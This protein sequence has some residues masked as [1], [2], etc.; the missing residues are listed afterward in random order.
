VLLQGVFGN[1]IMNGAG[2]FMS[3]SFDYFDNQTSEILARWQKPGD[4]T[5]EPQLR[6]GRG[7]GVSASSSKQIHL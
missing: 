1:Q 7:N 2:G 4:I 5:N 6:F 3:A